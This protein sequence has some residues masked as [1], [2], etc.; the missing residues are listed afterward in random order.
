MKIERVISWFD[1]QTEELK[2]E[3]NVDHISLDT[4]KTI[5]KPDKNDPLM[6]NPYTIYFQE[7]KALEALIDFKFDLDNFIYQIDCFQA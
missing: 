7:A 1:K 3:Y 4:L 2:G 5:F 6:Y